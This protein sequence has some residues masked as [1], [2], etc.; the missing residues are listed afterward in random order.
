VEAAK[1]YGLAADQG[2]APAQLNLAIMF[3]NGQG[4]PQNYVVAFKLFSLSA[5]QG[6]REAVKGRDFIERLMT[7]AQISEAQKLAPASLAATKVEAEP[8]AIV[9]TEQTTPQDQF[10]MIRR[11]CANEWPTDFQMRAY[12]EKQQRE[13]IQTLSTGQPQDIPQDQFA[14]IRRKCA[15][16]WPTDFQMRAYCE[17]QQF[18][19]IR[20]LRN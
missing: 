6:N 5:A 19:A 11:K 18:S 15:N 13:A 12:C 16:E 10:A 9:D 17:K 7:P 8:N 2:Y 20:E 14:M 4:V 3:T 1:R